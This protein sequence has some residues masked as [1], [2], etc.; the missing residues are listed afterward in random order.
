MNE[1]KLS[2]C[3]AEF[4]T[5]VSPGAKM[6][7]TKQNC[8]KQM[9]QIVDDE[10]SKLL[11][12]TL[13]CQALDVYEEAVKKF[14]VRMHVLLK[15]SESLPPSS[16]LMTECVAVQ[17]AFS[18]V[19]SCYHICSVQFNEVM[20][21]DELGNT[22]ECMAN[23]H[24]MLFCFMNDQETNSF[25]ALQGLTD[26]IYKMCCMQAEFECQTADQ[27]VENKL[28][29]QQMCYEVCT[30][31]SG[32][33]DPGKRKDVCEKI[34]LGM[35]I[36]C[37]QNMKKTLHTPAINTL[38][39]DAVSLCGKILKLSVGL[40][41]HIDSMR[42]A[43]NF[44]RICLNMCSPELVTQCMRSTHLSKESESPLDLMD[45]MQQMVTSAKNT[46]L[47]IQGNLPTAD[48]S[49]LASMIANASK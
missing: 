30:L 3:I 11:P 23:N 15:P 24:R 5:A 48:R 12:S 45:F 7:K 40:E 42:T 10:H 21:I 2:S 29:L 9:W 16:E 31:M 44:R 49:S 26:C 34:A 28:C 22:P 4:P 41:R 1:K 27:P 46:T 18:Q 36:H 20:N 39:C 19:T 25:A 33:C 43:C 13:Y 8:Y 38:I 35:A 14:C 6:T 47:T 32:G 37:V 17:K